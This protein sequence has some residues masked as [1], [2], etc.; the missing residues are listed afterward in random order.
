MENYDFP[1]KK[2]RRGRAVHGRRGS[3]FDVIFLKSA[4]LVS[5]GIA[6]GRL[7]GFLRDASLAARFG[8][9]GAADVA[10]VLL[11]VPDSLLN[12]LVGGAMSAALIPEFARLGRGLRSR[13]LLLQA[14]CLSGGLALGLVM[15]LRL[16]AGPTLKALAPGLS[17]EM[18]A[19]ARPLFRTAL[20]AIPLTFLAGVT[21]AFL[22]SRHR[23]LVPSLGTLL[24]NAV[25]I[26]AIHSGPGREN[27]LAVLAGAVV[28]SCLVRL[29]SQGVAIGPSALSPRFFRWRLFHGDLLRRYGQAVAA[30]SFVAVLPILARSAAS[31]TTEGGLALFNYAAK[32]VELPLGVA[33]TVLSVAVFPVLS[34]AFAR[35]TD[36]GPL[37]KSSFRWLFAV[38]LS[39][40]VS[41]FVFR[42][43]FAELTFGWGR[44]TPDAMNALTA[45][46]GL[47][48]VSLPFQGL[49]SLQTA[50][51]NAKRDTSAPFRVNA[52]GALAFFPLALLLVFPLRWGLAGVMAAQTVV[53]I[54]T[55][56]GQAWLLARRHGISLGD[57]LPPGRVSG[58][59]LM[60]AVIGVLAA[61]LRDRWILSALPRL[62]LAV[63]TGAVLLLAGLWALGETAAWKPRWRGR[64]A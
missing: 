14:L 8:A 9:H 57:F 58:F 1:E 32:L 48:L 46:F 29:A 34:H 31:L 38:S 17:P 11:L 19:V 60:S 3:A 4:F 25:L 36:T 43:L 44:M 24:F 63:G 6:L 64:A 39:V 5:V 26:A 42:R 55:S 21:T 62:A 13:A 52:V 18:M 41:L 47:G 33:V 10:V 61:V 59:L 54:G 53:F 28:L 23:F 16:S 49:S 40:A 56:V 27:P 7:A 2:C 12:L 51:F 30:G 45:L 50:V 22:Q 35:G 37:L 15:L 20:W